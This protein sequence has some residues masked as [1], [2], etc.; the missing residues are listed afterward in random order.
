LFI[1]IPVL[2]TTLIWQFAIYFAGFGGG[3]PLVILHCHTDWLLC[4]VTVLSN[5]WVQRMNSVND[6]HFH[7]RS[8]GGDTGGGIPIETPAKYKFVRDF[9]EMVNSLCL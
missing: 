1:Q 2:I 6:E 8:Y 7:F 5:F 3:A 4:S 9:W